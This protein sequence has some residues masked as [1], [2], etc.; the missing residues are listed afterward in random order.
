MFDTLYLP[1]FKEWAVLLVSV[2]DQSVND[3]QLI[4]FFSYYYKLKMALNIVGVFQSIAVIF[5]S[6]RPLQVGS[7]VFWHADLVAF[8]YI[9]AVWVRRYSRLTFLYISQ[10]QTWNQPLL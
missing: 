4:L 3:D 9:L 8:G 10:P 7:W 5:A 1:L 6:R 2:N